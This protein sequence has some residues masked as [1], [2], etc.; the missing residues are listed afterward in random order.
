M[1]QRAVDVLI[2]K[3]RQLPAERRAQIEDFVD[4]LAAKE[5]QTLRDRLAPEA[6]TEG[7][8]Q[9]IVQSVCSAMSAPRG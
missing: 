8:M 9:A 6:I 2:E 4:F 5:L 7:E 3:I 1:N